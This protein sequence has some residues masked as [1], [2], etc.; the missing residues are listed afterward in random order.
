MPRDLEIICL[1]C[2]DKSPARRYHNADALADDL[3]RFLQGEPIKARPLAAWGRAAKWARRHP[4]LA[5]LSAMTVAA[6]IA[7][8]GVLSVA[9]ARVSDAVAQKKLEAEAAQQ[10]RAKEATERERAEKLAAENDQRRAEAVRHNE[11]LKREAERTRRAAYALQ[12]AQ[13]AAMC[14]RDPHRALTLLED[15]TRCPPDLRDF[16]W[17]YLHRLCQRE[18]RVYLEHQPND[19]LHAIAYSP[20][21]MFV[22]TAGDSGDVRV[23][24][25]RTGHTW[26]VLTGNTGRVPRRRL[27]SRRGSDR[28][29]RRRSFGTTVGTTP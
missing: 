4:S 29:G 28:H 12:L 24:D 19:P 15:A 17:A 16:T 10:A 18:E 14:E 21:G 8:V 5:L 11:E 26:A 2:L 22:A 13:V 27:Q 25:P 7:L 1:K 9:Y 6:T 23:W 20:T 3:H